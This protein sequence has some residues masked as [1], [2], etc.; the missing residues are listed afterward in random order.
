MVVEPANVL[1][2]RFLSALHPSQG[3]FGQ[4]AALRLWGDEAEIEQYINSTL[5]L[6]LGGGE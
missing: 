1:G 4:S 3:G 2:Q 5:Y 6:R